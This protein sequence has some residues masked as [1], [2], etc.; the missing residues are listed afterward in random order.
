MLEFPMLYM[1]LPSHYHLS[2][3]RILYDTHFSSQK[4]KHHK[5]KPISSLKTVKRLVQKKMENRENLSIHS[6]LITRMQNK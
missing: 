6:C 4:H 2:L 3:S 5:E 1:V